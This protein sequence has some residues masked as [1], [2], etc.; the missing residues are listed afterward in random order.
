ILLNV[1][2]LN[3]LDIGLHAHLT[4][5]DSHVESWSFAK[6]F[7]FAFS[8]IGF[9]DYIVEDPEKPYII[10]T[11]TDQ[12]ESLGCKQRGKQSTGRR[13]VRE[14]LFLAFPAFSR[15]RSTKALLG[16]DFSTMFRLQSPEAPY[17]AR[18]CRVPSTGLLLLSY[19]AYLV[20]GTGVFWALEGPAARNSSSIFQ[21]DKWKLLQN[22]TC[23]D[24]PSLDL[25]IRVRGL[26]EPAWERREGHGA[27]AHSRDEDCSGP[28]S[29]KLGMVIS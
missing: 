25:L 14:K 22:F 24:G 7:Y 18:G 6:D 8:T 27:G 15:F 12:Q 29:E 16:S 3:Q 5:L 9:G 26:A 23:L 4:T 1:V 21:R 28:S 11:F 10:A 2:F 19:L 20:L 13:L 17:W